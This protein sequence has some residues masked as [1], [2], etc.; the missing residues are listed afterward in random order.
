MKETTLVTE[1]V[2]N[3]F[4]KG[5]RFGNFKY[6]QFYDFVDPTIF[7]W[8]NI[9]QRFKFSESVKKLPLLFFDIEVD[10]DES[11]FPDPQKAHWAVN[12]VSLF[13]NVTNE[14]TLYI[15]PPKGQTRNWDTEINELYKEVLNDHEEYY[16]DAKVSIKK[17]KNDKDL[18]IEFWKDVHSQKAVA[19]I[20]YNSNLFDIP[21]IMNRCMKLFG[22]QE[23][24]NIVSPSGNIKKFGEQYEIPEI[25]FIDML[26]LY[27]P[28]SAGGMAFGRARESYSL[29]FIANVEVKISKLEYEGSLITLYQNDPVRFF[30]YNIFDTILLHQ[31]NEKLNHID[32]LYGLALYANAPFSKALVGRSL[33]YQFTK[34]FQYWD[35]NQAIMSKLYNEETYIV[36]GG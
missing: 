22:K 24:K 4:S 34:T 33:L 10:A 31:L 15:I 1:N 12:S 23:Y 14:L 36:R 17:F 7:A 19:L 27:K 5:L 8:Y 11:G 18:L 29:D 16:K 6:H 32:A 21:Y 28:Q 35:D 2:F 26:V 25:A 9:Q 20:G 13:N 3:Q 30:V